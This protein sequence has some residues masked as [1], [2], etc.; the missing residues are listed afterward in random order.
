MLLIPMA[1]SLFGIGNDIAMQ[2]AGA[3]FFIG[4]VQD[5]VET[6]L[7]SSSDVM[8]AAAAEGRA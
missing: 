8:F 6:M 1:C 4:I 3:G 5:G 2:V 7:N